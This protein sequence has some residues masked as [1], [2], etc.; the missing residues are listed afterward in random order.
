MESSAQQSTPADTPFDA[1]YS[2]L[3][4]AESA[5]QLYARQQGFITSRFRSKKDSQGFFFKVWLSCVHGGKYK[6]TRPYVTEET[7]QRKTRTRKTSC[8]WS[9]TVNRDQG[10]DSIWRIRVTEDNHNHLLSSENLSRFPS[11]RHMT[12][13]E[14]ELV[15]DMSKSGATPKVIVG[16]IRRRNPE[17]LVITRDIYNA[18]QKLRNQQLNG[19]TSIEALLDDFV[20]S[21]IKHTV[22]KNE[23]GHVVR[24][25]FA[26]PGSL[27]LLNEFSN[28]LLLD[29]TYKTNRYV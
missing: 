10:A 5:V 16:T 3:E 4:E 29:S 18:C 12:S 1:T 28:V 8:P 6:N 22:E 25:F 17:S 23:E 19:R 11:A 20:V 14:L 27:G 26:F 21:G 15:E 9:A 2:T 7:R 13:D 24:L